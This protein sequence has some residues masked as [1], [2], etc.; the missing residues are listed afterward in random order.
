VKAEGAP[1]CPVPFFIGPSYSWV[2]QPTT[3]GSGARNKNHWLVVEC[4]QKSNFSAT[5]GGAFRFGL[6][7]NTLSY[8]LLRSLLNSPIRSG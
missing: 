2:K 1:S 3:K 6:S 4:M 7:F 5:L 8:S